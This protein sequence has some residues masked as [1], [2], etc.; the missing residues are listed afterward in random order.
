[1]KG[2]VFEAGMVERWFNYNKSDHEQGTWWTTDEDCLL[3]IGNLD[4]LWDTGSAYDHT[5]DT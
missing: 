5:K 2:L 1:M 3:H 4:Y